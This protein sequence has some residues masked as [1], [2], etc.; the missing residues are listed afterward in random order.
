MIRGGGATIHGVAVA[1]APNEDA[2]RT[3][4]YEE[5][6]RALDQ[7][8]AALDNL[9]TRTGILIAAAAVASSFL[10]GQ[11]LR[12]EAFTAWSWLAIAALAVVGIASI[13]VLLPWGEWVFSN[14]VDTLLAGY[15]EDEEPA[16][17]DEMHTRLARYNQGHRDK[18]QRK[19]D[20]LY[21]GFRIA[22]GAFVLEVTFWLI[23]LGARGS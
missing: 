21:L 23:D 3:L 14:K 19:L 16:T 15:V 18:N 17:I 12:N 10:G 4:V 7:Q 9:R 22:S 11:A 8:Q 1:S 13:I 6:Q 2:Q 20:W 5:S